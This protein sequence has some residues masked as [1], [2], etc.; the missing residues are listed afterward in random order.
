MIN[1]KN[2][3]PLTKMNKIRPN[4]K[5]HCGSGIKYKKCHFKQEYNMRMEIN[6]IKQ[7]AN[8][9]NQL[10]T[11]IIN[12]PGLNNKDDYISTVRNHLEGINDINILKDEIK[13][14]KNYIKTSVGDR[15]IVIKS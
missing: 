5:C 11:L 6:T 13:M 4:D 8:L 7:K 3:I 9:I 15:I 12:T 1:Y 2:I 14:C 10:I